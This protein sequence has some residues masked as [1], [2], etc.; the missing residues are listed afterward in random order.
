MEIKKA[1]VIGA[2]VMGSGIAAQLA[3]AG[4]EVELMD[5]VPS[6]YKGDDR[7]FIA[8]GAIDRMKKT[9]PAPLM[10]KR[11][12]KRIRPGNIEDH[13]DR[14]KDAD[15]IIEAVIEN[16]DIK[17]KIFKKID[18][19]RKAGAIVGSNTSTIPLKNLVEG[20]SAS[21]KK[22]FVITHFFNP[23]RY[24]PLLELISSPDNNPKTVKTLTQFMDE[25]MGKTVINCKDTPGFIAN[26][27]GTHWLTVAMK[28]AL[29][30]G[31]SP[32]QADA[33]GGRPMGIPKT[34]V[35]ALVDL[36]GVDLIPH[37]SKSLN[38]NVPEGDAFKAVYQ[39]LPL[40]KKMIEDGY[41]GRKGKGGF[42]RLNK[43][44]GEKVKEVIDLTSPNELK[45]SKAKRPKP[46]VLNVS[47]KKGLRGLVSHESTEGQ[48]AWAVLKQVLT[49]SAELV[50]AIADDFTAIDDAMKLG[51]NWKHGPFELIDKMGVD[52]FI[53]KLEKDGEKVPSFLNTAR[54]KSFYKTV[55]GK[56]NALTTAGNYQEVKRPEGVTLLSDIKRG[57]KPVIKGK[58]ASVWD[59]GDDV[60]CFELT[61]KTNTIDPLVL[62]TL[63]KT[64][65][66][67]EDKKSPYKAL[68]IHNGGDN[69][70]YGANIGLAMVAAKVKQFWLVDK[71]VKQG[72]DVYKRLKY[73][74]FPVVGAPSGRALGGG[75][76]I[77][78]H[79][80]KVQAHAETYMGL[81]EVGVGL[82]P[83]W[84][85]CSE[86]MARATQN[87]RRPGGPMPPV[88]QIFEL[89]G[90]AQV[91]LS[92][93]EAKSKLLLRK[94]DGITMNKARLLADAKKSALDL[95]KGYKPPEP[96][97]D[98]VL[99]GPSGRTALRMAVND[100][101]LKGMATHYDVV[102]ID[103]L[104]E[105]L[106]GGGKA[107]IAG[108]PLSEDD[109]RKLERDVF[110]RLARD[111]RS[112]ARIESIVK[113]NKPLREK[114]IKGLTPDLLRQSLKGATD[115]YGKPLKVSKLVQQ[116]LKA[117]FKNPANNNSST[118]SAKK[119]NKKNKGPK[120]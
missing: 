116:K 92:A 111:K 114:P 104:A 9:N 34:G 42:Y 94:E 105:I 27:I 22:D 19:H 38:N 33:V 95:V 55:D 68:V 57:A 108:A 7:D 64:I 44:N 25:K 81:V 63:N 101:Y 13:M 77:L 31:L 84:G 80:D 112:L 15:L 17:S 30:R 85:G 71:L 16:P 118:K 29:D 4:I 45:Y 109:L 70:C 115:L 97:T 39:D 120:R 78:L 21:F 74:K 1:V 88:A 103:Q 113:T 12:A 32:E 100:L 49:Y 90:T 62:R 69:F 20:Q 102:I 119:L 35:F 40:I 26:R 10:H 59:I 8:K 67:I 46:D 53:E 11:N 37:I 6:S 96:V 36:V 24:M 61:T 107:D 83:G 58:S 89:I 28:E 47:K 60:L 65:D 91:P 3:N 99:P 110:K 2:G 93:D 14:L 79:C 87:K 5:I 52:W 117:A 18:A 54:G 51:Y 72:Q 98:M 41:T 75:C 73:A 76:E 86:M 66:L 82:I 50:P 23:P 43:I 56:L 48:Y 106:T